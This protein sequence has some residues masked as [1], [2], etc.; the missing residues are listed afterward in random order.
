M[1]Q[2]KNTSRKEDLLEKSDDRKASPGT[3][4]SREESMDESGSSAHDPS[5]SGTTSLGGE[6]S[7]SQSRRTPGGVEGEGGDS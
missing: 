1:A 4:G 2:P 3:S 5:S 6:S 7:D